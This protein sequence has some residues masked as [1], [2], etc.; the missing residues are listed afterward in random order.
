MFALSGNVMPSTHPL[1]LSK[2]VQ[3]SYYI[4]SQ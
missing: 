3:I 4:A 1:R 2:K